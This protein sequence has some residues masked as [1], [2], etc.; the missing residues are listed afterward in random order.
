LTASDLISNQIAPLRTSDSGEEALT[1]MHAY[2]VRHL[3]IV[4]NEKLLGLISEEDI[5]S[6]E[7]NEPIGS[8]RLSMVRAFCRDNEHIFEV[9]SRMA[10]FNLTVIPVIDAD[11]SYIGLISLEFLLQFYASNYSFAEPGAILILEVA[12][13]N[14][15]LAEIARIVESE[16][17]MILSCF[18]SSDPD[19]SQLLVTI[20]INKQDIQS[21]KTA[22]ERYS[23]VVHAAF[24]EE[25]YMDGLKERY[26]S[27]MSYL[28]V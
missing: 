18:L 17:G 16:N 10:R 3:P 25:D 1:L 12:K 15:S 14:Y 7:L 20:K 4:N 8:Y 11:E 2:H 23:Y 22:F 19:T 6:N 21:I 28:N 13:G 26:D 27:L 5:L 24:S 9:M